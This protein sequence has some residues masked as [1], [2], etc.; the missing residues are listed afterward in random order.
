MWIR[1]DLKRILDWNNWAGVKEFSIV[2][3]KNASWEVEN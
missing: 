2:W 1:S 3:W